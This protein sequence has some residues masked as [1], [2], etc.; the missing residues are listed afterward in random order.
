[1]N[2]FEQKQS[3]V[4]VQSTAWSQPDLVYSPQSWNIKTNSRSQQPSFPQ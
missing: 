1:M 2:V 3:G 4:L